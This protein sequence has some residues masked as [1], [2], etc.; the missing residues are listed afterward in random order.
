[1]GQHYGTS[2]VRNGL[3]LLLDAA[4][5][6]SY[7]GAGST[8]K[9]ISGNGFDMTLDSTGITHSSQ[10]YFDLADG[11]GVIAQNITDLS[12]CTIVFWLKT[13]D[14]QALFWQG[15]TT[16]T[17]LGAYSVGNK[18]YNSGF[19][20]PTFHKDGVQQSN[21][22]DNIRD[23]QWHMLEF[24]NVNLSGIDYNQ[25]NKY[26]SFTF[27]SS[28]L[29]QIMIYNRTLTTEESLKNF[30]AAKGRFGL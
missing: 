8:W 25:F 4:N 16:G 12:Q 28:S 14:S 26:G 5:P 20:S 29:A 7:P 21:I 3:L 15:P 19:G 30:E 11:G 24:K 6:K 27:T 1:M 13:T 22:Y 18:F 23:G 2:I 17:Y 10:G 9:D